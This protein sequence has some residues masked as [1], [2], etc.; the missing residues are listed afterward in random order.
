MEWTIRRN[1][2]AVLAV[3]ALAA[4]GG[5]GGGSSGLNRS[6]NTKE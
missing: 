1:A 3:A 4:C 5:E 2:L 6:A